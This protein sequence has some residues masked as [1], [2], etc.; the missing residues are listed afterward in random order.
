[1]RDYVILADVSCDLSQEEREFFGLDGYVTGHLSIDDGRDLTTKLEWSDISAREMFD[2]LKNKKYNV[3]TAPANSE[4]VY[5]YFEQY[6]KKDVDILSI[7]LSSKISGTYGFTVTA[8]QRIME[9]YPSVKV[10]CLD[11]MRMSKGFGLL[12]A[13]ACL[14]KKEGK[15]MQEVVEYLLSIR[16]KIHQMG[17]ID[18]LFFVARRGRISKA[19][20]IFGTFAGVRP[21]GDYS[22]DGYTNVIAKAKGAK[23]AMLATIEYV[24]QTIVNPEEQYI[25]IAHSDREELAK[26]YKKLIEESIKCKGVFMSTVFMGCAPNIGP[27]MIAVQ[28]LGDEITADLSVES[29]RL[30]NILKTVK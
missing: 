1:M 24:K 19:K 4:E 7:S 2:I 23:R 28:F 14:K 3:T 12:V 13:Y 6:A 26:E 20:A 11:S 22:A 15:S 16:N 8:A 18:D 27:G 5:A 21:M 9:A 10:Y 30:E 29:Q 17:P 25:L